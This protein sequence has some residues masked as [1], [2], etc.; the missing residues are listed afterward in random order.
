MVKKFFRTFLFNT[1]YIFILLLIPL[2]KK[3]LYISDPIF[4]K[5]FFICMLL[6]IIITFLKVTY[7][8]NKSK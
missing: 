3:T 4:W 2:M 7:F 6:N 5:L 8:H 1:I